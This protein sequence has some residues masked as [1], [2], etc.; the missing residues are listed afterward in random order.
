LILSEGSIWPET[1]L[2]LYKKRINKTKT[3]KADFMT[4]CP[5]ILNIV[6]ALVFRKLW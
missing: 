2:P 5:L 4:A 1:I 6:Q 3:G